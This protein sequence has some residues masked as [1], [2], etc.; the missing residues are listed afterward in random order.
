MQDHPVT[1]SAAHLA[2]LETEPF[3]TSRAPC[4]PN[5]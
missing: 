3:S 5:A 4:S 2:D 1:V